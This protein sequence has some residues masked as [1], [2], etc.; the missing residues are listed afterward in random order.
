MTEH[1]DKHY[2]Q[3][4]KNLKDA[5]LKMGAIIEEMIARSMKSLIERD[6]RLAGEVTIQEGTVNQLEMEIDDRCLQLLALR[7]PT[8]SDLRFI[9][10]GLKISKD[11][12]RIGDLAVNIAEQSMELNREP[13]LKPYIDL[14]LMGQKV[15]Q[16]VRSVLES[17]VNRDAKRAERI[18]ELDDEVDDLNRKVFQE[19]ITMMQKDSAAVLRGM[20]LIWISK[21][22]ER[23]ADHATNIA[24]EVIFMVQGRDIR[25]GRKP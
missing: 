1:T 8:A 5:I 14:P 6:S 15:Q 4:L 17:F 12:E 7:Q 23:I 9:T 10:I 25:H 21:Q 2:E 11:L 18:C 24:E 13:Q 3:E 16:M 19:L 20:H 22:L